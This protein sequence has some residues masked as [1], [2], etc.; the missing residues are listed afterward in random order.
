M[1]NQKF[2]QRLLYLY[3]NNCAPFFWGHCVKSEVIVLDR[4]IV[5]RERSSQKIN[6][7]VQTITD[8]FNDRNKDGA[9]LL[10]SLITAIQTFLNAF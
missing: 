9:K 7:E 2:I 1:A 3:N 10:L 8:E 4:G 6:T 5:L